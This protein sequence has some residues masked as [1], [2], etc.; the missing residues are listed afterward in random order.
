MNHAKKVKGEI[1]ESII[2]ATFI[3]S[4][5]SVSLPFGENQRY[6]MVIDNGSRL[7][8]VQCKSAYK[9]QGREGVIVFQTCS[10][11]KGGRKDYVDEI[12]LFAIYSDDTGKV[13]I[14]FI[15][16]AP[17]GSTMTLRYQTPKNNILK[18]VNWA[19][20]YEFEKRKSELGL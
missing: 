8:K 19:F 16:E 17:S 11:W 12:D 2:L 6:D 18:N 20:D 7:F 14:V 10:C 1:S 13:Y 9:E 5:A 15:D 3:R 4:G